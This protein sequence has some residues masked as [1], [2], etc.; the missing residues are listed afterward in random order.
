MTPDKLE[1]L[2][3][4]LGPNNDHITPTET[5]AIAALEII[6]ETNHELYKYLLAE[7]NSRSNAEKVSETAT[8]FKNTI[9]KDE[10]Y[11]TFYVGEATD[12]HLERNKIIG[13]AILTRHNRKN[14]YNQREWKLVAGGFWNSYVAFIKDERTTQHYRTSLIPP[15]LEK[16]I[17]LPKSLL[18]E[19]FN[20][21][22][23]RIMEMYQQLKG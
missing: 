17:Y 15:A 11:T 16:G 4:M 23:V 13:T 5:D 18:D 2:V 3:K 7:A 21:I 12:L 14:G 1:Q 10:V 19:V 22:D 6:K 9:H 8:G 20:P